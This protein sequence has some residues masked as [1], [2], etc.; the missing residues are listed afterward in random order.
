MHF[1]LL[2]F[3]VSSYAI[4]LGQKYIYIE[5][6]PFTDG[7]SFVGKSIFIQKFQVEG[8]TIVY[9]SNIYYVV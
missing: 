6:F 1:T 9:I 7:L 8:F 5:Y 2:F 3:I 4:S